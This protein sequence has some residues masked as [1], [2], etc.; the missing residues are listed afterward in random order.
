MWCHPHSFDHYFLLYKWYCG[1]Y[2]YMSR[3]FTWS[4]PTFPGLKCSRTILYARTMKC[5]SVKRCWSVGCCSLSLGDRWFR[6]LF[7]CRCSFVE[8][9][10]C[11]CRLATSHNLAAAFT[12]N[13]NISM[14]PGS[15]F[16]YFIWRPLKMFL[17]WYENRSII[18]LMIYIDCLFDIPEIT[19]S[20]FLWCYSPNYH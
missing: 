8:V 11:V 1:L 9:S 19:W 16:L 6:L 4:L 5:V 2:L 14:V 17:I 18:L 10:F 13:Q 7:I 15:F 12:A 20:V 3:N